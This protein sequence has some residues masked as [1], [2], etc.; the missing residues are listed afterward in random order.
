VLLKNRLG[1]VRSDSFSCA[2]GHVLVV[3][4]R[5]V[6]DFFSL[7]SEEKQAILTLLDEAKELIDS[8]FSPHGYNIG[9]NVGKAAGQT[10]MHAHV[11]LIPRFQG[12]SDDPGGGVRSV[13]AKAKRLGR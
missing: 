2:P 10:R 8:K 12:D 4:F 6:A 3:P 5:H 9:V 11:H 13:L 1:Y 7:T